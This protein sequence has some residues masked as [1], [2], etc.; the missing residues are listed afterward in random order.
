MQVLLVSPTGILAFRTHL[1]HWFGRLHTTS[2]L[3]QPTTSSPLSSILYA[4]LPSSKSQLFLK[5]VVLCEFLSYLEE[6][7]KQRSWD[8]DPGVYFDETQFISAKVPQQGNDYDCGTFLLHYVELPSLL[9]K[10]A[11]YTCLQGASYYLHVMVQSTGL[12]TKVELP[13]YALAAFLTCSCIW[14]SWIRCD[15]VS[16]E[17]REDEGQGSMLEEIWDYRNFGKGL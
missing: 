15:V 5:L 16:E 1:L 11:I 6:E 12:V 3:H 13:V 4:S 2:S 10:F 9:L 14:L 7:W 8:A 17:A